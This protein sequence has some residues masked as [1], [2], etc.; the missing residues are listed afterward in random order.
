MRWI[1]AE[2]RPL[3]ISNEAKA[4][5]TRTAP[6][7]PKSCCESKRAST[8]PVTAYSI[9]DPKRSMTFHFMERAVRRFRLSCCASVLMD[10]SSGIRV[11][12]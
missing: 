4:W 1:K 10:V 8:T 3:S 12:Y 5:K 9:C 7:R 11:A 6:T 2:D